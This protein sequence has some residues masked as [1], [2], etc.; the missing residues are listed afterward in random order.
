M[1]HAPLGPAGTG[2]LLLSVFVA[3][4]V[5]TGLVRSYALRRALLDVPNE[6]SSH[7]VPTPR[8]GGLAMVVIFLATVV[9]L[10]AWGVLGGAVA[11]ALAG[12]GAAVAAIG[13]L[14]DHRPV[15]AAWRALVHAAAAGWALYWLGGMPAM[16][17]G[18]AVAA[19]GG[20]GTMLALLGIVWLTN[21]YNFMDGIDGLA[22]VEAVTVGGGAALLLGSAGQ[23]GLALAAAVVAAAAL[24]FLVWNWPPARIFMGDVGSGLLGYTFGVMAVAGERGGALPVFV[25][26]ILLAV[27]VGDATYTLF[28]RI[29]DGERWYTAHRSHAYQRAVQV[30]MPHRRVTLTV[31]LLN[32]TVLLPLAALAARY[33]ALQPWVLVLVMIGAWVMWRAVQRRWRVNSGA[34][35]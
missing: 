19:L 16:R 2:V 12:G 20:W 3:S 14:D 29:V 23:W 34:R 15:P 10:G 35:G 11:A 28:K 26:V 17:L 5:L 21:L 30:G 8:G 13:W 4:L 18:G 25:W 6:R 32:V 9:V 24:G 22:G 27:F 1:T 7:T 31:L 33:P